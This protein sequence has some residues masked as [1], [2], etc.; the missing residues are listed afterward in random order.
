MPT[1]HQSAQTA[2]QLALTL[3]VGGLIFAIGKVAWDIGWQVYREKNPIPIAAPETRFGRL[4]NVNIGQGIFPEIPFR[5]TLDTID[6]RLPQG[7]PSAVV[8][9]L[10]SPSTGF[11]TQDRA[12]IQAEEWG[13]TTNPERV[14]L[15]SYKWK[16]DAVKAEITID[17]LTGNFTYKHDVFADP[18][19]TILSVPTTEEVRAF[20]S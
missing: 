19:E 2:R 3:L 1:L 8:F 15:T 5:Y 11:L 14:G 7:T 10:S 18:T 12:Q 4:P 13:F 16:D 6:G 17:G 9:H 20:V